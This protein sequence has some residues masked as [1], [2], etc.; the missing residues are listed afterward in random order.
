MRL[1]TQEGEDHTLTISAVPGRPRK[2]DSNVR[3]FVE[4]FL[5][6]RIET[7]VR[8]RL[9][10]PDPPSWRDI[11]TD[12]AAEINRTAGQLD[13]TRPPLTVRISHNLPFR[14]VNE[15]DAEPPPDDGLKPEE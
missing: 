12:M 6:E 8:R 10:E 15:K 5:G 1:T 3:A 9:A 13:P 2:Y 11:A 4:Y 7:Y 14:V